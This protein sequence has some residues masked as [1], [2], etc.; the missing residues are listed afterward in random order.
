MEKNNEKIDFVIIWVDGNDPEWQKEK[1]KYSPNKNTDSRNIRY[2]DWENLKYW[3]RGVEKFAP[4]VNKIYFVTCGHYPEW[5]NKENPKLVCVKHDDYMSKEYLPTFSSH[6]IELN[7]HRIKGLS[8][9]F[10]YFND[11]MFITN[12][13][14]KTDFF[15]NG[16]PVDVGLESAVTTN[17]NKMLNIYYNNLAIINSSFDKKS[18]IK[19]R[20]NWF[21]LKYGKDNFRGVISAPWKRFIGFYNCHCPQPFLKETFEKVW[22][23]N[24]QILDETS[25]HKFR[26]ERDVSQYLLRYW[27]L[28][29]NNFYPRKTNFS[30]AITITDNDIEV[31]NLIES[32]KK[33]LLCINDH[34]KITEAN[35][36]K[37]KKDI[38]D[39]FEKILPEKSSFEK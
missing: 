30:K 20:K 12:Y 38:I 18:V 31:C 25:Q 19:N 14:K 33:K 2:R 27:Q 29:E 36:K 35:F 26:N 13:V 5:L 16:K 37:F 21:S 32:Q 39:S 24:K 3:F 15:K 34:E 6:P 11:D 1:A 4:W 7:L 9:Q 22:K 23:M 17:D 10:V 28:C 8:E